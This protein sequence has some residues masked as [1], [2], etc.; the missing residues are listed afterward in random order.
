MMKKKKLALWIIFAVYIAVIIYT[1]ICVPVKAEFAPGDGEV[2]KE[3]G[4][5]FLWS[6]NENRYE[7]RGVG[8]TIN[9]TAWVAQYI[10]ITLV[11]FSL[12]FQARKHVK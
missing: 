7:F 12:M 1:S 6:I 11:F 5:C 4:Y 8:V 10:F 9:V 2:Y 3:Y